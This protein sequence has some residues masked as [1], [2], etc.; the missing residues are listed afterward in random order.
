MKIIKE[1]IVFQKEDG[2]FRYNAWSTVC[3][4]KEGKLY[5]A[6]S[7]ERVQHLCPFGKNLMA[8]SDDGGESWTCPMIINDTWLDDRDAGICD[9]G[10]GKLIMSFFNNQKDVYLRQLPRV[11]RDSEKYSAK[12]TLAY[13]DEYNRMPDNFYHQGS[14]TRVSLDGGKTWEKANRA[15]VS[16]PHGP[17]MKK[18]G[19]LIWLGT[20]FLGECPE[21]D[22]LVVESEDMGKTWNTVAK[23]DLPRDIVVHGCT[24]DNLEFCEPDIE[25]LAD[26]TLLGIV[27]VQGKSDN[28]LEMVI[29]RSE[30]GGKTWTKLEN[31]GVCGAPPHILQLKDGRVLLTYSRRETPPGIRGMISEDGGK[32]WGEEFIISDAPNRDLGYPSSA[33]LDD[34]TII[35]VYYKIV[36]PAT[37]TAIC[38]TKWE[39]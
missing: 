31:L 20:S 34:G 8:V 19:K 23:L 11:E 12:M 15:P 6:W 32:T 37:K 39:A 2:P 28:Y 24:G 36:P 14:F 38:Y 3:R 21:D 27:R 29:T 1:G 26:G 16:S 9:M 4:D 35:T 5:V 33:Q 22:I 18:D 7:G 25:E 17:K 10:D 30:D 13:I